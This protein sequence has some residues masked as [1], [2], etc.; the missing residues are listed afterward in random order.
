[1]KTQCINHRSLSDDIALR[2]RRGAPSASWTH[3]PSVRLATTGK[4]MSKI[5]NAAVTSQAKAEWRS[6]PRAAR[7]DRIDENMSSKA[8]CKLAER[9]PRRSAS[10][11]IQLRTEHVPL[12]TYLHRI[13]RADSPICEQCGI[14]PETVHRYLRECP[15]YE[16]QR[17]RL[18]GNAGEAVTQL[19]TLLNAPRMMKHLFRYVHNTRRFHATYGDLT[20]CSQ[21]AKATSQAHTH[22]GG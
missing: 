21:A 2:S 19:R 6:S 18:D 14:M 7:I 17:K 20:L 3:T 1:M 5:L 12:Q 22:H 11:L 13:K 4:S 15:A 9:L 16:E 8:Y 10:L